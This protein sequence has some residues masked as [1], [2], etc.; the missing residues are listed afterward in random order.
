MSLGQPDLSSQRPSFLGPVEVHPEPTPWNHT[1]PLSMPWFQSRS[2]FPPGALSECQL[3]KRTV[4]QKRKGDP[5]E[6]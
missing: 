1:V 6:Q 4:P 2:P 5:P 3:L